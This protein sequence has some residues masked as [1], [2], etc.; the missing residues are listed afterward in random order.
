M[1]TRKTLE[2]EVAVELRRGGAL[3][4]ETPIPFLTHMVETLLKYAGLGGSVA[5]RELRRLDDGHHVIEDV[6]IALGRAL[7]ALLGERKDI[8]R[9]GWAAVPMDDS[10]AL[11]AVDL[12][13]RPY[14]VVKAKLPDVSIGGY[15]LRMF[16]HFVRTLAAEAKATIHIYTRGAD[17][18]HKVEAAHK[19]LGLALRQAMAPGDSPSTKGVL[20]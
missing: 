18:H 1:Y 15:P 10:F 14:W 3:Q 17:P 8:A 9:F 13:G 5:A 2:T 16:P 4:V 7:D 6:A 11:A 19:S 20:G 12:G